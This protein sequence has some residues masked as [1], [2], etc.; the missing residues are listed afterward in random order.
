MEEETEFE[1]W[2]R[3]I[4]NSVHEGVTSLLQIG[5]ATERKKI[6]QKRGLRNGWPR[7]YR[8]QLQ[9][10]EKTRRKIRKATFKINRGYR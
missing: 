6:R 7:N 2:A 4:Q 5:A 1:K 9:A 8:K 3:A 10:K